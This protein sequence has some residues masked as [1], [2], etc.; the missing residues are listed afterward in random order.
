MPANT[1]PIFPI[2]PA[3][4]WAPAALLTAN[5]ATNGTGTVQD[6]FT[7]GANG[8]RVSNVVIQ[9]LGTNVQTVMRIFMNNGSTNATV[10]NNSLIKEITLAATTG[11][12]TAA[13]N[14]QTVELNCV[15][16]PGYK[17][18]YTIGTAVANGFA[19]TCVDAGD[20]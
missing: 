12:N 4:E 3:T 7:A 17:L 2:A 13:L 16:P 1:A 9:P 20:Y 15:L 11:S 5:A 8:A 14:A 6:F 10:G 19:V 18:F